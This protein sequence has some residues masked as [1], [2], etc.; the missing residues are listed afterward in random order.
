ISF[1]GV[2]A[3]IWSSIGKAALSCSATLFSVSWMY[4]AKMSF[5]LIEIGYWARILDNTTSVLVSAF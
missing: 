3:T 5:S 2:F 1:H 4:W